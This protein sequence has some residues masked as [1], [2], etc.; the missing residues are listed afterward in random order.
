MIRA[1]LFDVD[2]TLL[3][4]ND[5]HAEAWRQ[6]FLHFGID[7]PFGDVREQIGKGG[8]NLIPALLPQAL[9]EA[10]Q[11]EI[12]DYRGRLF[13]RDFMPKA[14]PF[15]GVRELFERIRS[16]GLRLVLAS[17]AKRTELDHY[18]ELLGC[19][20]LISAT[21]SQD[22]V[23]HS[24]P[25]PD[26]FAAALG[27]VPPLGPDE[28]WVVGDTPYDAAAARKLG[29]GMIGFRSGGFPEEVLLAAGAFH[30]FD[31][32]EDMLRGWDGLVASAMNERVQL[33]Q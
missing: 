14:K 27:K 33:A 5:L 20:D 3:D 25:C 19:G 13:Q 31:G 11:E 28:V 18:V 2:G 24:K 32:P 1:L 10:K 15:P 23:E 12:Q 26:I 29:I 6:A 30:L 16:D 17:S 7:I 9:V 22:D 4:S 21:T 8:D